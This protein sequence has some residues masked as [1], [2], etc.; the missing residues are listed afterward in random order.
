M[1][2]DERQWKNTIYPVGPPRDSMAPARHPI[3]SPSVPYP[4]AKRSTILFSII[5]LD[6]PLV[7]LTS[8][9]L[10]LLGGLSEFSSLYQCFHVITLIT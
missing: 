6:I 5:P 2:L 3:H 8:Q 9:T 10:A 7:P 4:V 1:Y